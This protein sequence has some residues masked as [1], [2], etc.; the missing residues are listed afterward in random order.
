M[1]T[2][3]TTGI[4]GVLV[5]GVA[6]IVTA[7]SGELPTEDAGLIT[8]DLETLP[9]ARLL[10]VADAVVAVIFENFLVGERGYSFGYRNDELT[11]LRVVVRPE[12]YERIPQDR[13]LSED[14]VYTVEI[15]VM[16]LVPKRAV[17]SIDLY[18]NL[19][20]AISR[21]FAVNSDGV[22]L[23]IDPSDENSDTIA[24]QVVENRM[25]PLIDK[26]T[27]IDGDDFGM[28]SA[29]G[30]L[31]RFES[32]MRIGFREFGRSVSLDT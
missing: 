16:Q 12:D 4:G 3:T 15:G 27:V 30:N 18:M 29:D 5:G 17:E 13:G 6:A 25:M 9:Q 22:E 23:P 14:I 28:D 19:T 24:L 7:G 8:S 1:A 20:L 2:L 31:V 10:A 26:R 32:R 11:T 21:L